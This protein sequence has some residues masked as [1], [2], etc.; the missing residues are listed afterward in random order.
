[1]VFCSA[2]CS[3]RWAQYRP[4]WPVG[5][6]RPGG[7]VGTTAGSLSRQQKRPFRAAH[8]SVQRQTTIQITILLLTKYHA[9]T[10]SRTKPAPNKTCLSMFEPTTQPPAHVRACRAEPPLRPRTE[11]ESPPPTER[12]APR[13]AHR[14]GTPPSAD[15]GI[16]GDGGAA[17]E[18]GAGAGAAGSIADDRSGPKP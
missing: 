16:D 5:V 17:A 15:A 4:E 12:R 2:E 6:Q 10:P 7:L 11:P 18:A 13:V 1:M 9:R 14:R 3:Q 8:W